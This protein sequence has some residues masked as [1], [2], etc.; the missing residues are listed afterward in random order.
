MML[1]IMDDLLPSWSIA[2]FKWVP[3]SALMRAVRT[4]MVGSPPLAYYLPQL[5]VLLISAVLI[6][7]LDAWLVR[8]SDR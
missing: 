7:I 5:A 1:S 2:I 8:R 3:S 6:L 4:S